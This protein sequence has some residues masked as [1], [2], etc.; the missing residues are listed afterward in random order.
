MSGLAMALR[1]PSGL[2]L[3]RDLDVHGVAT[4]EESQGLGSYLGRNLLRGQP[5]DSHSLVLSSHI[6]GSLY[7]PDTDHLTGARIMTARPALF[8]LDL[9]GR[10]DQLNV[11][12]Q[13]VKDIETRFL[14]FAADAGLRF[15][16]LQLIDGLEELP[17]HMGDRVRMQATLGE[18]GQ[19]VVDAQIHTMF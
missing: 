17:A 7:N 2:Y 4:L 15:V 14:H 16:D 11:S 6:T 5:G 3:S 10:P 12:V 19:F 13:R 8:M 9:A 1:H 18:G